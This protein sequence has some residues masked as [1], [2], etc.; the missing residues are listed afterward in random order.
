M[1]SS[2]VRRYAVPVVA[3][4]L[5]FLVNNFLLARILTRLPGG[6]LLAVTDLVVV[7][8]VVSRP[9]FPS[10]TVIYTTYAVLAVLGHIGVDAVAHLRHIPTI[11]TA[12]LVFDIIVALGRYRWPGFALGLLAFAAIVSFMQRAPFTAPRF[13]AALAVA[14]AGL[15]LGL[16]LRRLVVGKSGA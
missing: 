16:L 3:G 4:V 8:L 11:V 7:A 14:Y 10:I 9:R 2:A 12:A 1:Q 6:T 15:A 13:V 5:L